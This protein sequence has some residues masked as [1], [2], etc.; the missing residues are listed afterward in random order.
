ML[1]CSRTS[2]YRY[3]DRGDLPAYRI[4]AGDHGPLL[5]RTADVE[6]FLR[7]VHDPEAAR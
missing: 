6:Q 4:G 2:V 7:P 5:I 3:V 1:R